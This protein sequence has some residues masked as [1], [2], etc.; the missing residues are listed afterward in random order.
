MT[1]HGIPLEVAGN[2][3]NNELLT[4]TGQNGIPPESYIGMRVRLMFSLLPVYPLSFGRG[5]SALFRG[6]GQS[7]TSTDSGGWLRG[8]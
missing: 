8:E 5:R 1:G 3:L 6:I 2:F 4:L 7:V